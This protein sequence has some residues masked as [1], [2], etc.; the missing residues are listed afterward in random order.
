LAK[1]LDDLLRISGV[2]AAGEFKE[3]GELVSYKGS[4]SKEVAGMAAQFVATVS[5]LFK[6]LSGA[7]T[8]MSKMEWTPPLGW[9]F[10]G[11]KYTVA[12]MGN[13][14]VFIETDKADFNRLFK[15]LGERV[16]VK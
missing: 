7:F 5:M 9:A 12:I 1:T 8:Q 13:W 11:G 14:G 2:V 3:T 10:S 15:E 4:I 6:T 16:G